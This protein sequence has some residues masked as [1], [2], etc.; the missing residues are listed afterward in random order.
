MA[1]RLFHP[2]RRKRRLIMHE[3]AFAVVF[4]IKPEERNVKF[5]AELR[6]LLEA[7]IDVDAAY[8]GEAN[9][10]RCIVAGEKALGRSTTVV[11]SKISELKIKGLI[12]FESFAGGSQLVVADETLAALS[13]LEEYAVMIDITTRIEDRGGDMNEQALNNLEKLKGAGIYIEETDDGLDKRMRDV[14]EPVVIE[15]KADRAIKKEQRMKTIRTSQGAL[16][17]ACGF[18]AAAFLATSLFAGSVD[19]SSADRGDTVGLSTTNMHT[20]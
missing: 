15:R 13:K 20:R 5:P 8:N 6:E 17:K 11:S 2:G 19:A 9:M 7:L 14:V 10:D 18:V 12:R 16:K 4:D 1:K 3:R